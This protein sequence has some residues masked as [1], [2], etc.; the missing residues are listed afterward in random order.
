MEI[1]AA[2]EIF[3]N[4]KHKLCYFHA[5]RAVDIRLGKENFELNQRKEIYDSFHRA[6]YAKS[7]EKH[8]IQE[9]YLVALGNTRLWSDYLKQTNEKPLFLQR[10]MNFVPIVKYSS[11]RVLILPY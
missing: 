2:K 3:V 1:G 4:V 5:F 8:E 7:Q 6:V 11:A 10:M 9:D